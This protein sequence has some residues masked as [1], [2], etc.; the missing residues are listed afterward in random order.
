MEYFYK[1]FIK[2]QDQQLIWLSKHAFV[3]I[4]LIFIGFLAFTV[5]SKFLFLHI[6]HGK[7]IC[8]HS[9]AIFL[10]VVTSAIF[11]EWSHLIGAKIGRSTYTIPRKSGVFIFEWN[12]AKNSVGKFYIMSVSGSIGGLLSIF[13]LSKA[14]P[15]T[16][17]AYNN[18][19][20]VAAFSAFVF[21]AA[22]EWPVLYRTLSSKDPYAELE[23][24]TP[25]VL[26]YSF[27]IAILFGTL[28]TSI[29]AAT[30]N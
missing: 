17:I 12:F 7:D 26:A 21:G 30:F 18:T 14:L 28:A 11:H 23:K 4:V 20:L 9:T 10:G 25:K 3:H 5:I 1:N 22:I 8:A 6:P 19:V 16:G 29:L 24:T 27:L 2:N 15:D 13:V